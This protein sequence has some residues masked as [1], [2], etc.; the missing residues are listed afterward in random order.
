MNEYLV[1]FC[2]GIVSSVYF[3]YL[4]FVQFRAARKWRLPALA[5]VLFGVSAIGALW[6]WLSM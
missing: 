4:A 3:G 1:G 5:A 6:A 2:L